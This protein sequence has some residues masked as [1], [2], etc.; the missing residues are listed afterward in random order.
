MRFKLLRDYVVMRPGVKLD[1]QKAISA[2]EKTVLGVIKIAMRCEGQTRLLT[3][4]IF[5]FLISS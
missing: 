3:V 2:F 1:T 4:G 5:R